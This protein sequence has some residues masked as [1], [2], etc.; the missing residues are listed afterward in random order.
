MISLEILFKRNKI[1]FLMLHG[2]KDYESTY[3]LILI[4]FDLFFVEFSFK[5]IELNLSDKFH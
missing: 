2:V 4:P 5:R 3:E 1:G